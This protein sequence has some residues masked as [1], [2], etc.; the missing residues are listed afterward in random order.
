MMNLKRRSAPAPLRLLLWSL[1]LSA[2]APLGV[3]A[4]PPHDCRKVTAKMSRADVIARVMPGVVNLSTVMLNSVPKTRSAQDLEPRD[5]GSFATVHGFGSGFVV[6]RA[7]FIVTNR[8]V[9][10]NAVRITVTLQDETTLPARIVG[11]FSDADVALLKV[12]PPAPLPALTWGDS[13]QI[14]LGNDVIAIGNPLGLGGSVSAGI[15]SG[16][17]RD[18]RTT[19]FDDFIQTDAP[20]NH[21][22]SGGPLLD[23]RGCVIGIN[24]AIFSPTATSGSI[25]IS[26]A[27]PSQVAELVVNR[28][29]LFGEVRAGSIG[30]QLQSV[31]PDIGAALGLDGPGGAIIL[32]VAADGGAAAAG[33]RRGD[34]I[35]QV[36]DQIPGDSRALLRTIAVAPLGKP[37]KLTIWRDGKA[38]AVSPIVHIWPNPPESDLAADAA[39]RRA[40]SMPYDPGL[41]LGVLTAAARER[42]K[43]AHGQTGVL[44]NQ[45]LAYSPADMR[46]VVADDIILQAN[47]HD[48]SAPKD[49]NEQVARARAKAGVPAPADHRPRRRAIRGAADASPPRDGA[50]DARDA[51]RG[52]SLIRRQGLLHRAAVSGQID[53]PIVPVAQLVRAGR[54]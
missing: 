29:R 35:R 45:V 12:E 20:I 19:P 48:V 24:T 49:V 54:S 32:N 17:N 28:T 27:L 50:T 22:N 5:D 15:V 53:F 46:G 18:I 9:V 34:V 52:A 39:A 43:L 23:L 14:R 37:L 11:R 42:A 1:S 47:Q 40:S 4:D 8:H 33:L 30:V 26:F 41:R 36:G 7:G 38:M 31:T 2:L 13:D 44:V 6:D 21:G 25:G 3:R 16:L 51:G 10:E